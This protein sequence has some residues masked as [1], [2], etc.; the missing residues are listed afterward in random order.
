[1]SR[2]QATSPGFRKPLKEVGRTLPVPT[3]LDVTRKCFW[4]HLESLMVVP[5]GFHYHGFQYPQGSR[6]R[7]LWIPRADL[8]SSTSGLCIFKQCSPCF[9]FLSNSH[10]NVFTYGNTCMCIQHVVWRALL[11]KPAFVN[12]RVE[13][14]KAKEARKERAATAET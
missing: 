1:M 13:Q 5:L 12:V 3:A 2:R 14:S 9:D 10:K 4:S 6:N 11:P 8:Y 7:S